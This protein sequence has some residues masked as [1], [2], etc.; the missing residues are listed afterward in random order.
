MKTAI[1]TGASAGLGLEFVRHLEEF[2]PDIGQVWL[3]ARGEDALR[4]AASLLK[5]ARG[6]VL[7]LDIC[8]EEGLHELEGLLSREEPDVSLLVSNAG[9]GVLG[10]LD[11]GREGQEAP[12]DVLCLHTQ[13]GP[14]ALPAPG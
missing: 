3:I 8:T 11:L 4:Q 14:A 2:F 1:I 5:R 13:P 7:P 6:R 9:M 10:N 12:S